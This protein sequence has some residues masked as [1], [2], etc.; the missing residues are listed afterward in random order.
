MRDNHRF[1][2]ILTVGL[3]IA[4]LYIFSPFLKYILVATVLALSTSHAYMALSSALKNIDRAPKW[5]R[6]SNR[7]IAASLFTLFFLFMIFTPLLYFLTVTFDQIS[8]LNI[9]EIKDTIL[10]LWAK[11]VALTENVP[12]LN[13]IFQH[14][15]SEGTSLINGSSIEAVIKAGENMASGAGGLVVQIGWILIFYFIFNL[16]GAGILHFLATLSPTSLKHEKYLYKECTGTVAVVFYGSLFN[17]VAQGVAFGILMVFIGGYDSLYL[18]VLAGF[19]SIIPL[20]GAALVYIPVVVLEILAGNYVSAIVIVV[21]AWTIMGFIIDN[22]LRLF[23][24]AKLKKMFGFEYTMNEVLILLSILAG[25]ATLGFW[26]LIIGP[27]VIAL[28][29]AA[30]NICRDLLGEEEHTPQT[31]C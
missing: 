10:Q 13:Q 12:V 14:I 29:L 20:V 9:N 4:S 31:G 19:C 25:I 11:F 15:K 18:G 21:F 2:A 30:A 22:F 7:A 1:L 16:Y 8:G 23:F 28:T 17:M 3:I 27:S 5:I 24:I 6:N 26:G